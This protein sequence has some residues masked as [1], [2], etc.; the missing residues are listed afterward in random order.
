MVDVAPGKT[1]LKI[2]LGGR[3]IKPD[4]TLKDLQHS[5]LTIGRL[6]VQHAR[7]QNNLFHSP[8]HRRAWR[9]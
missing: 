1:R 5:V 4:N 2:K 9:A 6:N 7:C 8:A 3:V